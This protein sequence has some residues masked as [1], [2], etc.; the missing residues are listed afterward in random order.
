VR[1]RPTALALHGV[2]LAALIAGPLAYV[3]ADK[4]VT[5]DINGSARV[6][7]TYASTVGGVLGEQ[8]VRVGSRDEV[9]PAAPTGVSD[10]LH[11]A[12]VSAR[13]VTLEI[14]GVLRQIWTTAQTVAELSRQLGG[15][16][17]AAYLS[18]SRSA[19]IPLTG[20]DL[21]VRMPKSLTVRASGRTTSIV[22]T[23]ATWAQVLSQAGLVLGP[24]DVLSV[25]PGSAPQ[26]AQSV[27]I[28]R[29]SVRVVLRHVLIPF[30]V[31]RVPD[32]ALYLGS[33]QV[34]RAGAPGQILQTWR[35]TLHDGRTVVG[36]LLS[37]RR[38]SA[39]VSE[40]IGVGTKA[41]PVAPPPKTSVA[42]LNWSALADCESGGNP[43]SVGGGGQYFGL[44]QFSLGAWLGVGGVGNPIDATTSEQ[45]YRAELLYLRSGSGVWPYCGHLLF[46]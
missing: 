6:V 3:T 34:L 35:Y 40:V 16:F 46:T 26:D 13:A 31:Q 5:L 30:V 36:A 25:P 43:R 33:S 8:G 11:I 19:R 2:V 1:A 37:R 23:D 14:D 21:T 4:A 39:P 20:L 45:T 10:G 7:R 17:D 12:V 44:Y 41:R 24:L 42:D 15:R 38:V 32:S 29:V 9:S 27:V 22:S 18:V 28:T